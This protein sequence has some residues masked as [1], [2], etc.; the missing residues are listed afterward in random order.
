MNAIFRPLLV[1]LLLL[2]L[3]FQG[4]AAASMRPCV[5]VASSAAAPM[6]APGHDHAAM[7]RAQADAAHG[8]GQPSAAYGGAG[9][10]ACDG[11]DGHDSHDGH[12]GRHGGGSCASC[13]IGAAM[14]P[15]VPPRLALARPEFIS[16]P[17]QPGHLPSVDPS[18]PERPPRAILA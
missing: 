15:T 9:H 4:V 10:G 11:H 18:L 1:W 16:I 13:C 7:L 5:A 2:A 12:D 8:P 3:P 6:G 17:F 14:A